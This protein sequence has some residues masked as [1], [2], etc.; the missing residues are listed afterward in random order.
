MYR[1]DRPYQQYAD[2]TGAG[3]MERPAVAVEMTWLASTWC[4]VL[5]RQQVPTTDCWAS[6]KAS[7]QRET[8]T[9]VENADSLIKY[10][11]YFDFWKNTYILN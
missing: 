1:D 11:F 3:R 7:E 4:P 10:V 9:Q 2:S 8:G 6:L 5:Q